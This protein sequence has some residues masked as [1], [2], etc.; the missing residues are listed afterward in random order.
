MLQ[1]GEQLA[2]LVLEL[3]LEIDLIRPEPLPQAPMGGSNARFEAH[4]MGFG[5]AFVR[6]RGGRATEIINV[7]KSLIFCGAFSMAAFDALVRA[8]A[9]HLVF[10]DQTAAQ[11][12]AL[13]ATE[14]TA[15]LVQ[16]LDRSR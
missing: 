14:R 16:V 1:P 4:R 10:T 2:G 5:E 7:R 8:L 3:E 12:E 15:R 11:V 9:D 13:V 6:N